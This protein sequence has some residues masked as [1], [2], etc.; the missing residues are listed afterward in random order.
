MNKF[1]SDI[2]T[3]LTPYSPGEQPKDKTLL[4][5]NTNENPYSPSSRVLNAIKLNTKDNL[6]LYPDPDSIKLKE[7]ISKYYKLNKANIFIGNGSDEILAFIF[8][9]LLKKTYPI[10]FPN[11]TYSFYPA[12]CNL[13]NVKYK[14]SYW[15]VKKDGNANTHKK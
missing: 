3:K 2:V 13:Y 4:K 1:W 10:L 5:L 7:V 15:G 12:Y 8:Q 11:I 14:I 6:R 9:G